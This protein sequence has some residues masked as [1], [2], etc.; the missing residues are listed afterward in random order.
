MKRIL[1]CA[2]LF[3][4]SFTTVAQVGVGNTD[5]KATLD[6]TGDAADAASLDGIIAPRLTGDE[7]RAKTYTADQ[8]G[9]LVYVTAADSAPAGQTANVSTV[10]YYSFDGLVWNTFSTE[11]NKFVDGTD[12]LDA[13]YT[14]GNVGIGTTEPTELL[15]VYDE[16]NTGTQVNSN[17]LVGEAYDLVALGLKNASTSTNTYNDAGIQ[18]HGT[19]EHATLDYQTEFFTEIGSNI[20]INLKQTGTEATA[21]SGIRA[22]VTDGTTLLVDN[23]G[24]SLKYTNASHISDHF[25]N[26]YIMRNRVDGAYVNFVSLQE[27][28]EI[29]FVQG[30]TPTDAN[31]K[32]ILDET[33]YIGI[34]TVAPEGILDVVSTDSGFIMPR[35][36]DEAS[37]TT[38]VAGMQV[39]NTTD[40]V[41]KY[42]DG[43][44][45]SLLYTDTHKWADGDSDTDDAV[46]SANVGIG[47]TDP[48]AILDIRGTTG[49]VTG[50]SVTRLGG[51]ASKPQI[52][53]DNNNEPVSQHHKGI[54]FANGGD[55]KSE[56]GM[57]Y[58]PNLVE[59]YFF[60]NAN[61]ADVIA[62]T[63]HVDAGLYIRN[64]NDVG[65]GVVVPTAKLD[66]DGYVKVGSSD[67]LADVTP[68][69]GTIRYNSTTDKFQGYANG[70]W[71]DLH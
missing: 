26:S 59:E 12:P 54:Q 67:D 39:Y 47:T 66:V 49:S 45:W 40:N 25:R 53:L 22:R 16:Y 70:A 41:I 17:L 9:A 34:G 20:V 10:G 11:P 43:T 8:T 2:A 3:A 58:N 60:I 36:A 64:T 57:K 69:N 19:V 24:A 4:A 29:K 48:T 15:H 30:T 68:T 52:Y 21:S 1:L 27:N 38:P 28:G 55:A 18:V 56:I 65:I 33:G 35:M 6:V 44:D 51:N 42:Y 63:A 14:D 5:P 23:E 71:V 46:I 13:V 7:L 31:T 50:I 62:G 32:M 61:P 37:V